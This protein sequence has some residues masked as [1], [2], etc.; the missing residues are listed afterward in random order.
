MSPGQV[1]LALLWGKAFGLHCYETENVYVL[2]KAKLRAGRV[3][4]LS[5]SESQA[6]QG[7]QCSV[8]GGLPF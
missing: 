7:P 8:L 6:H 1:F 5:V 2:Q 4:Q 3:A